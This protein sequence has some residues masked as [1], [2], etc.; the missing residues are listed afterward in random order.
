MTA[1]AQNLRPLSIAELFDRSF[2]LYRQ[3]FGTFLG[4]VALTQLPLFAFQL[5]LLMTQGATTADLAEFSDLL[6]GPVSFLAIWHILVSTL[7]T[8]IGAAALTQAISDNYLGRKV[9]TLSAFRRIGRSWLTLIFALIVAGLVIGATAVPFILML[10]IPCIGQIVGF[11]GA[12][13]VMFMGIVLTSLVTPV[14]VLEKKSAGKATRRA[15]ELAKKRMGWILG[16]LFLLGLFSSLAIDGPTFL[17][18]SLFDS[19]VGSTNLMT[20]SIVQQTGNLLFSALFLPIELTAITLMYFD[21]RIRFE[22]F[23]LLVL[24][25]TGDSTM[26]DASDLT[27]KMSL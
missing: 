21:L 19:F 11:A 14:V 26:A 23:D 8:Q 27:S 24:A 12:I 2:R 17:L 15:W 13:A 16:Y 6:E 3:N 1:F 10:F 18:Q 5:V 7:F 25:E 20:Q 9:S 4:I 22:G